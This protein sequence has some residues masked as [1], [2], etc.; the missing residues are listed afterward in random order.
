MIGVLQEQ[1]SI[2]GGDVEFEVLRRYPSIMN[3]KG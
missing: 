3:F 2:V 1:R